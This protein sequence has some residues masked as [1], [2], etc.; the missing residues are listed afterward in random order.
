MRKTE[1]TIRTEFSI[2]LD[3]CRHRGDMARGK[4]ATCI[5]QGDCWGGAKTKTR[6][7]GIGLLYRFTATSP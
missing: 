7:I 4:V 5:C 6:R 3:Q 1:F 2:L